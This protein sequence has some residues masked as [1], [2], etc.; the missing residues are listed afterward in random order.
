MGILVAEWIDKA[1]TLFAV[2]LLLKFYYTPNMSRFYKKKWVIVVCSF[3]MLYSII[4]IARSY[5]NYNQGRLLT[6]AELQNAIAANNIPINQDFVF[7]S[8]DGYTLVVPAGYAYTTFSSGTISMV[9]V[10]KQS[11]SSTQ[12]A[13]LVGRQQSSEELEGLIEETIKV[14]KKKNPT[15]AFSLESPLSI[16]DKRAIR[17]NVDVEKEGIPVKGIYVFTKSR[18]NIFEIMMTC[19]ASLFPQE[20]VE[21]EKVI[22]S[23]KFR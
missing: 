7:N 16:G 9:A 21:F 1:I 20:S 2:A 14:L 10:K 4:A 3:V 15:Y 8:P 23:L 11:Q 18:N 22:R 12:S 17:I 5:R 13:I 19:P 6:K